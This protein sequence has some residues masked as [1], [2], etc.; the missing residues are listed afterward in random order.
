MAGPDGNGVLGIETAAAVVAP[1][2]MTTASV[3]C[4]DYEWH[5]VVAAAD[6]AEAAVAG[7]DSFGFGVGCGT[8][9]VAFAAVAVGFGVLLEL[10][11]HCVLGTVASA[12][13]ILDWK[14]RTS[15]TFAKGAAVAVVV[16]AGYCHLSRLACPEVWAL[17]A[18]AVPDGVASS[19]KECFHRAFPV[20][21]GYRA[22]AG[23]GLAGVVVHSGDPARSHA[24]ENFPC[25]GGESVVGALVV[26]CV[27]VVAEEDEIR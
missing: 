27:V 1:F 15:E 12:V 5:A 25:G 11:C 13:G 21:D 22:S 6:V 23:A 2:G 7:V 9:V 20:V 16:A 3:A 17:V 14:R 10:D 26:D 4:V 8:A 18:S 24:C 19:S